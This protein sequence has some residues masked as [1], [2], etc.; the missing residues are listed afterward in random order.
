MSKAFHLENIE[1]ELNEKSLT[2]II[3]SGSQI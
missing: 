3:E 2:E 1:D